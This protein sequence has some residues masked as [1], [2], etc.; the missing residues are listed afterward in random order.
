MRRFT[1]AGSL[2]IA[3]ALATAAAAQPAEDFYRGKRIDLVVGGNAGGVY[4]VVAR[5]LARHMPAHLPGAPNIVV[6]N[7]PGA[8]SIKAAEWAATIAPRDGSAIVALYPGAIMQPLFEA[9]RKYRF[10]A[11][12]FGWL[13]SADSGARMCVTFHTSKT[14]TMADARSNRT[15]IGA[16][17]A[18]GST[19]D[20]AWMMKNL[21]GAN[22]QVVP[23]YKGTPELAIAMERGEID[24]ICGYGLGALRAEKP[25]WFQDR[26][27]NYL[28]QFS[29]G[30]DPE[31]TALGAPP[32]SQFVTGDALKI[33]NLIV[34]QQAFAR[35]YATPPG[36]PADRLALLRKAFDAALASAE[37]RSEFARMNS[38]LTPLPG[39]ELERMVS[40]IYASP[41]ALA[42]AAN[43]AQQPPE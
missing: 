28:V 27:L 18:G 5:A 11:R 41:A 10:D 38:P 21:S 33:V 20:Y 19:W 1:C 15:I 25:D 4:D 12:A 9:D 16:T 7:M 35:P 32:V 22:I 24:G 23:G 42:A 34:S 17:A 6:Q 37:M 40:A 3:M 39:H 8:G 14:R 26:K 2:M 43:K 30:P 29:Q 13:G 31:L 36:V